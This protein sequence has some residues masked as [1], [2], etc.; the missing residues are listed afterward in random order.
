[1]TS[2]HEKEKH[3]QRNISELNYALFTRG[4]RLEIF[5]ESKRQIYDQG[6]CCLCLTRY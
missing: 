3:Y 4:C 5:W 6:G 1:M 2:T